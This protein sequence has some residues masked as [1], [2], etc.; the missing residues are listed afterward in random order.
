MVK[1]AAGFTL[2]EVLVA[3][4]ILAAGMA[5]VLRGLSVA[6]DSLDAAEEVLTVSSFLENKLAEAEIGSWPQR[7]WSGGAG[8]R[9]EA[10]A[11]VFTWQCGT[12]SLVAA[13]NM[14]LTRILLQAGSRGEADASFRVGTEWLGWRGQP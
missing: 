4:V 2:V 11:G 3:A 14:V 7:E 8:G 6:V 10:P 5:A 1:G 9:W 12:E 13:T